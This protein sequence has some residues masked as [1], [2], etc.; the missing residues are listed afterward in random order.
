[1]QRASGLWLAAGLVCASPASAQVINLTVGPGG[2][3]ASL[4]AL[5]NAQI[6]G[7]TYVVTIVPGAYVDDFA[8]FQADTVLNG[9]G[10]TEIADTQPPN[11]KGLFTTTFS[12]TVNGMALVALPGFGID[13]SLGGNAA[14]IRE[15]SNGATQLNLNDAVIEGGQMGILTGSDSGAT[16]LD[17]VTITNT[18]FVNNG[19][20]DPA[21]FGH[22][23][24][25]G[26]AASL[27]VVNSLFCGQLIGHDIKSRAAMTVVGGSLLFVGSNQGADPACNIGS[28]SLAIDAPNGGQV[29]IYSNQIFQDDANQNGSL[30]RFGEEGVVFADN[31]LNVT[32]TAFTNYGVRPSIAIDE[33]SSCITPVIGVDTDTFVNIAV[34]V[35]PPSCVQPG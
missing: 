10:V 27:T 35:N 9:A 3:F 2:D 22:A 30:I 33:L 21:A 18:R 7:N 25:V 24:Y 28:A 32:N 16:H 1:M 6:A 15:Q 34:P 23:L 29:F 8:V 31:S 5:A 19:N 14:L 4:G 12:L 20:P 17:Q 11:L 13:S 26:D